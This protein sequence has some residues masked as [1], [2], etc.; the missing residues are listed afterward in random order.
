MVHAVYPGSFD[1]IT[2]GHLDIIKRAVKMFSSLTVA[3][4]INP[5]KKPLFTANERLQM[6]Q[7]AITHERLSVKIDMFEG[8]LVE[9]ARQIR[10]DVIL[11]GLR[12]VSD[13][14]FEFQLSLM[15]RR[16]EP[17][18]NTVYLMASADTTYLSSGLIKE[19]AA[20]GGDVTSF[21][22]IGVAERL[23]KKL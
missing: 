11:R 17:S 14:E 15:N 5:R 13:F 21:V 1:P 6:I 12:A 19:I 7:A 16:L 20:L 3:I 18:I 8:L 22:P 10:A 2:N 4:L 23:L 9:Y